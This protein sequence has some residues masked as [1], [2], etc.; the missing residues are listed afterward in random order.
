MAETEGNRLEQT[1]RRL[2]ELREEIASLEAE[3]DVVP[4]GS[5]AL[6][7]ELVDEELCRLIITN[8]HDLITVHELNGNYLWI[9]PNCEEFLGVPREQL[10]GTNAYALFHPDDVERITRD[11]AATLE[12]SES[13]VTFR[14][15][16]GDG[17]YRWAETR[18]YTRPAASGGTPRMVAI[19]RDV[20]ERYVAEEQARGAERK[21][22]NRLV[23]LATTDRLTQVPNRMSGEQA[24]RRELSRAR[25]TSR[26]LALAIIDIDRFKSIND[27]HGHL[28]GDRALKAIAHAV[29]DALREYDQVSRW[30]GEEFLALL[31]ETTASEALQSIERVRAA[32]EGLDHEH[33]ERVTISAGV[34]GVHENETSDEALARV[35]RALYRAKETGRNRV[36]PAE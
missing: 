24:L 8:T 28:A 21:L 9:S 19:T 32:V 18:S 17:S 3:L 27:T 25:R 15:R 26:P 7:D 22:R 36:E 10:I 4:A 20:H 23:R 5:S 12:T 14:L 29:R 31:P 1:L 35:D 33:G 13:R 11:H 30:G 34:G 16:Q 6:A 2:A